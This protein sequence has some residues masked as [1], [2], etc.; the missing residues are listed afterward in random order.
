MLRWTQERTIRMCCSPEK[1]QFLL[2]LTQEEV[3][4]LQD[5]KYLKHSVLLNP[6]RK[7]LDCQFLMSVADE[8]Q[9]GK[10]IELL[11]HSITSLQKS[12]MP[13]TPI[14]SVEIPLR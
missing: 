13:H 11:P 5:P 3:T 14:D 12:Q 6:V 9:S 1:L 2:P 8:L 4:L 10:Q 7:E